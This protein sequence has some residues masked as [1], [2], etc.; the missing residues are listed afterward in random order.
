[1]SKFIAVRVIQFLI[2]SSFFSLPVL[3]FLRL[4]SSF[5][6][7]LSSP[8]SLPFLSFLVLICYYGN[9]TYELLLALS[10][11]IFSYGGSCDRSCSRRNSCSFSGN[12]REGSDIVGSESSVAVV[13][14]MVVAVV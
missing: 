14:V 13:E 12:S 7:S 2:F 5:S 4:R 11:L 1:M 9:S 10:L 8:P 3:L 6:S